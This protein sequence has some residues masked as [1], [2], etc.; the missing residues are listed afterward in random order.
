MYFYLIA[1]LY[2][3]LPFRF[4]ILESI[5]LTKEDIFKLWIFAGLS[6]Q[7]ANGKAGCSSGEGPVGIGSGF[8]KGTPSALSI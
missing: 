6:S 5:K 1:S 8:R 7:P 4:S 2:S 3:S